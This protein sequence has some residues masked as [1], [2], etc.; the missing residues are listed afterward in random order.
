[1]SQKSAATTGVLVQILTVLPHLGMKR[2][3]CLSKKVLFYFSK[4]AQSWTELTFHHK[5][6]H[7]HYV[8]GSLKVPS[9]ASL[10]RACEEILR[11]TSEKQQGWSVNKT[12]DPSFLLRSGKQGPFNFA[13]KNAP[14]PQRRV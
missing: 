10:Q 6:L 8:L 5:S 12:Q 9:H 1:M 4:K 14:N 11:M 2:D 13:R 3:V 7:T